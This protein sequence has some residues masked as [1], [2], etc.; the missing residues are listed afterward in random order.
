MCATAFSELPTCI[1]ES[2]S[3]GDMLCALVEHSP[4][5]HGRWV[6]VLEFQGVD[7]GVYRVRIPAEDFDAPR[8]C[9]LISRSPTRW[10]T[11]AYAKPSPGQRHL[12]ELLPSR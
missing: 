10:P 12:S 2:P 9:L 11:A 4:R 6:L 5:K 3:S 7:R 1:A 8:L